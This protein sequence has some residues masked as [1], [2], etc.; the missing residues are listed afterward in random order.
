MQRYGEAAGRRAVQQSNGHVG[1]A[2]TELV[3]RQQGAADNTGA[4]IHAMRRKQWSIGRGAEVGEHPLVRIRRS[5]RVRAECHIENRRVVGQA[6]T[7]AQDLW[8][9]K[10][11]EP[12]KSQPI[13]KPPE[14]VLELAM[15]ELADLSGPQ[16]HEDLPGP[17]QHLED[18]IRHS[19]KIVGGRDGGLVLPKRCVAQVSLIDG[20]EQ[21]RRAGKEQLSVPAREHR[22]GAGDRHDEV[23]LRAIGERGQDEVH[24]RLFRRAHRPCRTHHDL[25]EVHR[26]SGPVVQFDTKIRGEVVENQVAAVE[27]LQHQDLLDRLGCHTRRRPEHQ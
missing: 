12:D 23:R 10:I 11:V 7:A 4:E 25:N 13:V 16:H 20:R 8:K 1:R 6:R 26:L 24:H 19:R 3:D 22:G 9:R 2:A 21:E 15:P 27:R 14:L 5:C 18:V 17:G